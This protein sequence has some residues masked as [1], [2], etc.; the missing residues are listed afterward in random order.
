M[1]LFIQYPKAIRR[2]TPMFKTSNET[3]LSRF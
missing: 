2:M 3:G 1:R